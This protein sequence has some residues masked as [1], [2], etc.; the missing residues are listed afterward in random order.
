MLVLSRRRDESIVIGDDIQITVIDIRGDKV[1]IG[2]DAPT[3]IC[4]H[5]K[6]LREAIERENEQSAS[7][8]D[9]PSIQR[10]A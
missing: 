8:R 6:E 10:P 4:V 3:A 5:R 1:R 7:L 2:I 9:L